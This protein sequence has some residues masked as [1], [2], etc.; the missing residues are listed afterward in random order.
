MIILAVFTFL[1]R[2]KLSDSKL[3][4]L[5]YLKFHLKTNHFLALEVV[6]HVPLAKRQMVLGNLLQDDKDLT[7]HWVVMK[8]AYSLFDKSWQRDSQFH[9]ATLDPLKEGFNELEP[10]RFGEK[11]G[12]NKHV[13]WFYNYHFSLNYLSYSCYNWCNYMKLSLESNQ[14]VQARNLLASPFPGILKIILSHRQMVIENGISSQDINIT[15]L[16][17]KH[18]RTPILVQLIISTRNCKIHSICENL[19]L[20][21]LEGKINMKKN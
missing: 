4:L 9:L 3:V 21:S 2:R 18:E 15:W 20:E 7:S 16:C 10:P 6:W 13:I 8:R 14:I 11:K 19:V 12:P 1:Q 5:Y 17:D